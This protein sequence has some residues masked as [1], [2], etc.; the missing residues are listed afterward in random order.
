MSKDQ[1]EYSA[2]GLITPAN[3]IT[4]SRIIASPVLFI[5][6]L[7]AEDHGGTS[8]AA[9]ILGGIFGVS[10]AVDGRLARA[11]N[12]VTKLGAFLDP[13][14]DKVVVLGC[15]FSLLS[16]GRFHWIPVLLIVLREFWI[17]VYRFWL[18][19]KSVIV[20]ASELAKWK[21]FA[22]G[23]MLMV[24]VMPTFQQTDWLI[25][26]LLWVA[27]AMTLITG[28]QYVRTGHQASLSGGSLPR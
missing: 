15:M 1:A 23:S 13:L 25:L 19:R 7:N 4:I 2:A 27:V 6:I 17:S 9:F 12:S 24:A 28:W 20:P 8:W 14:A 18:A 16:I 11:T 5:I 10:D 26:L 21:T 22:Q 3:L